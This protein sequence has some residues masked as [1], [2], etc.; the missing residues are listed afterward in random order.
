MVVQVFVIFMCPFFNPKFIC[1]QVKC[2]DVNEDEEIDIVTVEKDTTFSDSDMSHEELCFL[3]ATPSPDLPEQQDKFLESSSNV[4]D[5][6]NSGSP[7]SEKAGANGHVM[8]HAS[9]PVKGNFMCCT[10]C[11]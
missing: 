5:S 4:V 1:L 3:P 6:N 2:Y 7:V 10:I 8:N 11:F 9:S